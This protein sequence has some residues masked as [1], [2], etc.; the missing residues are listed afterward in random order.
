M[1]LLIIDDGFLD[2][3]KFIRAVRVASSAAV[4]LWLGLMCYCKQ[5][6]TDGLVPIDVVSD[7]HGPAARW[8]ARALQSLIDAGLVER[9]DE[10]TIR[11]HDYLDWNDSRAEVERKSAARK[12]GAK[13]R[14]E[15]GAMSDRQQG[16]DAPTTDRQ[17]GDAG[18]TPER[19]QPVSNDNDELS[20]RVPTLYVTETGRNGDVEDPPLTAPVDPEPTPARR[21]RSTRSAAS[22]TNRESI[23]PA[24]LKPDPTTAAKAWELGFT[25]EQLA[26][27]LGT[28]I[29]W[30]RSKSAKRADWQATFRNW[31]RKSAER[32]GLKPRK[33][34][35]A[36]WEEHQRNLRETT[37]PV[38][39]RAP[40]PA[41]YE[42]MVGGLFGG[43]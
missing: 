43:V 8:R 41:G 27:E 28:M 40:K 35:D 21:R 13:R 10:N 33:P 26:T 37:E 17:Q 34:R 3:A 36:A 2:H 32:Y 30:S 15:L 24:D 25:D 14:R 31:L 38:K 29:D 12:A 20:A 18:A 16:D 11:V 5:Q 22:G 42:R 1:S 19:R 6:L 9:V 39:A 23:C 4:H 7:V